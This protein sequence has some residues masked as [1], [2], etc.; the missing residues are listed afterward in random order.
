VIAGLEAMTPAE[1]GP[2]LD[3]LNKK[4]ATGWGKPNAAGMRSSTNDAR[5]TNDAAQR[6]NEI[7]RNFWAERGVGN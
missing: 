3:K 6:Q 7:N 2:L 5:I 4:I 1:R